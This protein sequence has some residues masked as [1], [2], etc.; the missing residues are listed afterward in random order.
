MDDSNDTAPQAPSE[1]QVLKQRATLLNITF[2]NNIGV[3]A[4][5]KKID[6][7]LA[8]TEQADPAQ[9]EPEITETPAA[10]DPLPTPTAVE[11]PA[12]QT[13]TATAV[14]PKTEP[15][16]APAVELTE[17]QKKALARREK[18]REATKL[19]RLRI[20]NLNPAKKDLP[21]EIF[22]VANG[23][24]GTI[25]KYI[26]YGELTDDGYHVPYVIYQQLRDRRFLNIRTKKD[27]RTGVNRPET[28]WAKEFALEILDPLTPEELERLRLAQA[29]AGSVDTSNSLD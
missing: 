24:I 3:E 26:P 7:K 28:S 29:A 21:G 10:L 4:L 18:I 13:I 20:T 11:A 23:V 1:L 19:V 16:P 17:G 22:T 25:R 15:A 8:E 14:T 27:P 12:A 5:R 6:E 2:S 9:P